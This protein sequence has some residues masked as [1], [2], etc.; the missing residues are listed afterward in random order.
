VLLA[1]IALANCA[2]A[3]SEQECRTADWYARGADDGR[4]ERSARTIDAYVQACSEHRIRPD[5]QAWEAGRKDGLARWICSAER[6]HE[7]GSKGADLDTTCAQ[8]PEGDG[9]FLRGYARGLKD[10][11]RGILAD[12][13]A[14]SRQ[15]S[16]RTYREEGEALTRRHFALQYDLKRT[17]WLWQKVAGR[18]STDTT[19]DPAPAGVVS[20]GDQVLVA[21]LRAGDPEMERSARAL[22]AGGE[23]VAKRAASQKLASVA[24]ELTSASWRSF[25]RARLDEES[26]RHGLSPPPEQVEA[27]IAGERDALLAPVLASMAA[28]GG[29]QV[30][31]RCLDL[32]GDESLPLGLRRT[33][34]AVLAR[35]VDA[36]DTATRA[37]ASA[38]WE[39]VYGQGASAPAAP[40]P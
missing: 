33:A 12:M 32:A 14:L 23:D 16:G 35:H 29:G 7:L 17:E 11:A 27:R 37:R 28:I 6:G 38:L 8:R 15:G 2:P 20:D 10:R 1:V 31:A 40:R 9:V 4:H 34:L 5:A 3:M 21:H 13:A 26:T 25:R 24:Q 30:I 36:G 19:V 39:R 22:A 18:L